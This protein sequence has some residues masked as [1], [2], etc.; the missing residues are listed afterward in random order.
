VAGLFRELLKRQSQQRQFAGLSE[1]VLQLKETNETLKKYLE[2]VM[3]RVGKQATSRLIK[4]EEKRLSEVERLG[5]FRR[6]RWVRHMGHS[7]FEVTAEPSQ[8]PTGGYGFR[9]FYRQ[10]ST[11]DRSKE[12]GQILHGDVT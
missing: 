2:A 11:G 8:L 6:N 1:Q 10:D 7:P 3:R 12:R 4:S 9:G 5:D